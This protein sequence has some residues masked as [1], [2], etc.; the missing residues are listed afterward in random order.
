MLKALF[1]DQDGVIVDT[2]RD[3]HRVAFN[4]TFEEFRLPIVWDVETYRELLTI[5]GGKERMLHFLRTDE[6]ARD[7]NLDLEAGTGSTLIRNLHLR[8]T[9][10]FI[11]M[12]ERGEIPLRPGVFRLM[13]EAAHAGITIGICTTSDRRAVD[14]IIKTLL[15]GIP[16]TFVIAGDEVSKKKPDP[17]I[18]LEALHRTGYS[19][20]ECLVIEDSS[21]GM[22][23]AG[24]AGIAVLATVNDYTV[25]EDLSGARAVVDCLGEIGG[26]TTSI[27]RGPSDFAA[28]GTVRLRDCIALL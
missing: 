19:P 15:P 12:I 14:S 23:A 11:T 10:I 17:E 8:K 16:F 9:D 26:Q 28:D 21:N 24:G 13:D 2:E 3:G 6:A 25:T 4:R 18:Y 20:G 5:G 1:F 7:L 22:K 27:L